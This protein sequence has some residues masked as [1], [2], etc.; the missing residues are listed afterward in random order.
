[1]KNTNSVYC[2]KLNAQNLKT[3]KNVKGNPKKMMIKR[4]N[5]ASRKL[6]NIRISQ[7]SLMV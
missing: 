7:S 6:W 2:A 5:F 4:R 1:M 3:N